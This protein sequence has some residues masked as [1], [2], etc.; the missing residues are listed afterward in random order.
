MAERLS[1]IE[2]VKIEVCHAARKYWR[3]I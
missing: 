3:V 2:G 1:G